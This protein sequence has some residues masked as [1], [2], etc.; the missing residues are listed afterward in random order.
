MGFLPRVTL[1]GPDYDHDDDDHDDNDEYDN[2]NEDNDQL[3]LCFIR[4]TS[5]VV[6]ASDFDNTGITLT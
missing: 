5:S 2:D 4:S 3:T 6:N 1:V